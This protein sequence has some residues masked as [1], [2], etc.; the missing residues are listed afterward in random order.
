MAFSYKAPT[1]S[2][3]QSST[4]D[5][6]P[7]SRTY[8]KDLD[9]YL[10]SIQPPP[11]RYG[12]PVPPCWVPLQDQPVRHPRKLRMVTIG[13]GI[14]AMNL[15][16]M[17]QHEKKLDDIVECRIYEKDPVLGGTW[18]V[19]TYPGVAC[20][21]PAHIYTFPFEPNPDWSAFYAGGQ[22]IH[23]YFMRTVKK[24]K[25]DRDVKTDHKIVHAQFDD[26]EGI[27]NLQVQH[28]DEIFHDWCNI[29]VSATGFLSHW[30]W[31]DIKGLHDFGALK[32]H[33]AAWDERYDYAGKKI[34]MIGNGSSAIQ[35]MP[36]LAKKAA[37]VTNFI[38]HPTWITPGLGS[39]VIDGKVNKIY[40]EEEKTRFR[41]DAKELNK[42]R[43]EIQGGSNKA[44]AMFVKDSGAQRAAFK[45][46]SEMMLQRLGGDKHLA[47]KLTPDWEVGCRRVTPGP[48]YLEA[49]TQSNVSL[50]TDAISHI[51]STGLVTK[52]GT[53][54]DLDVIVC[55]T[56]FDVSHR[57]P[58]PLIGLNG[59]DLAD[60]WKDEPLSYL[61]LAAP[62][63]PNMFFFSGPNAPV[64]HG[65]LMAGLGWSSAYM[66]DWLTKIS[67]EDIRH[68]TPTQE[69]TEEFNVYGDE[70]MQGL[71]WSGGCRSWYKNNRVDGR[72][73]AVWPGS[74]IC[75]KEVIDGLRPEDFNIVY[76]ARNRWR[77][78]GSGR[79]AI[80][81][82]DGAD[83]AFYL[84]K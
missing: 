8:Q 72:V 43:K 79:T 32:V 44:F 24:Y 25:L 52:D 34:A 29:L 49:F 76:R 41:E 77:W 28:K 11:T 66:C 30:K 73:T 53:H 16:Y 18:A 38:R 64:G 22:E 71:V 20:D 46:T 40:S 35:I 82:V 42:H 31:P 33:S 69:A 17:V 3:S 2:P 58:F 27:W 83:L 21:V 10:D 5:I 57:P 47:G 45:S 61:S 36:E 56:G 65:S 81:G 78:M 67:T 26:Y 19:N 59:I 55:A 23:D 6:A 50:V 84:E 7:P 14:S 60:Q 54:H 74:A 4:P 12:H 1:I 80:E 9:Q 51:D 15:A 39:A 70:I 48:G 62:N 13:G 37:H 75:Y 63:F 68:V